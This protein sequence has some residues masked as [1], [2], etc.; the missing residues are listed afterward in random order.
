M[1]GSKISACE[2]CRPHQ[3]DEI[4]GLKRRVFNLKALKSDNKQDM[5]CTVCGTIKSYKSGEK[6]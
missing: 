1:S 2:N 3:Q 5:Q 4:H 6:K